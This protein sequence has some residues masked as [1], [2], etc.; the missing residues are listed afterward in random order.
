M[1]YRLPTNTRIRLAP[2]NGTVAAATDGRTDGRTDG[3]GPWFRDS[4]QGWS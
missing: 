1:E 4:M 3:N 2:G